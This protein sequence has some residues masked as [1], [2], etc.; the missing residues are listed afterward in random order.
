M[1]ARIDTA[2][3]NPRCS[4]GIGHGPAMQRGGTHGFMCDA[5]WE[6][7]SAWLHQAFAAEA[8][9]QPEIRLATS[10]CDAGTGVIRTTG[11]RALVKSI[12]KCVSPDLDEEMAGSDDVAELIASLGKMPDKKLAAMHGIS[13]FFVTLEREQRGIPEWNMTAT[14]SAAHG[15]EIATQIEEVRG[16]MRATRDREHA[17]ELQVLEALREN[18]IERAARAKA[19][20][21]TSLVSV[22]APSASAAAKPASTGPVWKG[23]YGYDDD[24]DAPLK[25]VYN[26]TGDVRRP[27]PPPLSDVAEP[28]Q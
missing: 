10:I 18:D 25:T 13:S 7:K 9:T 1:N 15:A 20:N 19:A 12:P 6:R 22:P 27:L 28:A 26:F 3:H 17:E 23:P 14:A 16:S 24:D 21:T 4:S 2:I 5:C 8:E 11:N